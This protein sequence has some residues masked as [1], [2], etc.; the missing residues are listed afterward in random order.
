MGGRIRPQQASADAMFPPGAD[1]TAAITASSQPA[2]AAAAAAG[3]PGQQ[4]SQAGGGRGGRS[5]F[6]FP[7]AKSKSKGK[8]GDLMQARPNAQLVRG[9]RRGSGD[10]VDRKKGKGG[11]EREGGGVFVAAV[12]LCCYSARHLF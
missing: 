12:I 9:G 3:Q 1:L 10:M 5:G 4:G 7:V 11:G 2:A 6:S 8:G